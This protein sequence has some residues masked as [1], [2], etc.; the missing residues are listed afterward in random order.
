MGNLRPQQYATRA[1]TGEQLYCLCTSFFFCKLIEIHITKWSNICL[2]I[3]TNTALRGVAAVDAETG[4][5]N[6][7]REGIEGLLVRPAAVATV[8]SDDQPRTTLASGGWHGGGVDWEGRLGLIPT[9]GP[10]IGAAAILGDA[11]A[12]CH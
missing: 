4:L 5:M 7:T 1:S 9:P 8:D 11:A 6:A 2:Q 10:G 3:Y 12:H